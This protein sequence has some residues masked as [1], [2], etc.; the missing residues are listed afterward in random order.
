MQNGV[1]NERIASRRFSSVYAGCVF[2]PS[3]F[4]VPGVV[5]CATA[6]AAGTVDLGVYPEGP[7]P[8]LDTIASDLGQCAIDTLVLRDIMRWKYAKLLGNLTNAL[9][10]VVGPAASRE[11]PDIR[12]ALV[13]EGRQAGRAAETGDTM[14]HVLP[15]LRGPPDA[16]RSTALG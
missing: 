3:V 8:L 2:L 10:A 4:L 6:P 9:D 15:L 11:A 13:S 12:D 14:G 16:S 7:D 1:E 5:E